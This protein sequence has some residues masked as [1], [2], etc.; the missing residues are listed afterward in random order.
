VIRL[1]PRTLAG[2]L[3]ALALL[4]VATAQ[5]VVWWVFVD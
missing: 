4:A 5:L 1:W 2:R 3:V